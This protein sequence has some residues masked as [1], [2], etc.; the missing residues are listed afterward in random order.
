MHNVQAPLSMV[1]ALLKT[2]Q[3]SRVSELGVS[4]PV[5]Y[6]LLAFFETFP[7]LLID[8]G[9]SLRADIPFRRGGS[10]YSLEQIQGIVYFFG[11][12]LSG[13][14]YSSPS[15]LK[16]FARNAQFGSIFTSDRKL[17]RADGVFRTSVQVWYVFSHT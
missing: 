13:T 17:I 5:G 14:Q 7:V 3:T 6:M 4:Y 11:G 2:G 12:I 8:R 15:L 1:T 9:G 16:I 10:R